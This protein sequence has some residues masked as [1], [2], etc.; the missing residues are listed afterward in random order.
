MNAYVY[1][2]KSILCGSY[3]HR[4]ALLKKQLIRP[5]KDKTNSLIFVKMPKQG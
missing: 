3:V 1:G 2:E 5:G 4:T